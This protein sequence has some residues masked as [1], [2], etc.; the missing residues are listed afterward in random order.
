MKIIFEET[1][2][3]DKRRW[4]TWT[5]YEKYISNDDDNDNKNIWVTMVLWCTRYGYAKWFI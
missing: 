5:N 2:F 3:L 4:S 1:H